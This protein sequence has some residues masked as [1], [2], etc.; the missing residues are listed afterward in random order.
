M[1]KCVWW[2]IFPVD[3]KPE[4]AVQAKVRD[5]KKKQSNCIRSSTIHLG[6]Q[7]RQRTSNSEAS[8]QWN[9]KW[10][11]RI[12]VI[13]FNV[14]F[15]YIYHFLQWSRHFCRVI[16]IRP[17]VLLPIHECSWISCSNF[18][19]SVVGASWLWTR[20]V[21]SLLKWVDLLWKRKICGTRI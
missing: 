19:T 7:S 9:S 14:P 21:R 11:E 10:L 17:G 18:C 13:S 8:A 2:N 6:H 12:V 3:W 20:A 5:S 15:P 4:R 1:Q 16:L